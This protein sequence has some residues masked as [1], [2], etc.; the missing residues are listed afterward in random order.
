MFG[1]VLN[2]FDIIHPGEPFI[3]YYEDKANTLRLFAVETDWK[4][5]PITS[6]TIAAN[7][8]ANNPPNPPKNP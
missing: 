2:I 5:E 1:I 6:A 7:S 8:P 3:L 4:I